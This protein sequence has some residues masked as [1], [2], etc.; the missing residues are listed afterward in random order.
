MTSLPAYETLLLEMIDP[1]VLLVTLNRPARANAL[2]TQMGRDYLDLW[3]RLTADAGDV[4]C[5]IL[6][7]AGDKAFCAGGDLKERDGMSPQQWQHQHD[8]FERQYWTLVDLQ[9]PVIAAVNGHAYGGGFETALNCDFIYAAS[10]AR[11]ALTEVTLGLIPGTGGTQNLPRAIGER[12]AKE[13]L[14]TGRAIPAGQAL[15]WGLVNAVCDAP[16]LLP[17]ARQTAS[18]IAANAPLA[19]RQIKKAVR[20]GMQMELRTAYRFEV[21]AY[22]RLV[23]TDDRREGV[24]AFNEKRPAVF[25]GR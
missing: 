23:D 21:E 25:T 5:I 24:R 7:G 4:R 6:T 15:E 20:Y 9:I 2:N 11:F 10:H 19:V 17:L 3:S 22:N 18:R 12:R 14:L 1:Q 8:I 16:E 13:L